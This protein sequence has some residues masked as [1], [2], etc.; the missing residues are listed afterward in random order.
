MPTWCPASS[1]HTERWWDTLR[2]WRSFQWEESP[3]TSLRAPLFHLASW[4]D[5]WQ[6]LL[7]HRLAWSPALGFLLWVGATR[8][9]PWGRLAEALLALTG[10]WHVVGIHSYLRNGGMSFIAW[11][12]WDRACEQIFIE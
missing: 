1:L 6:R 12:K 10:P 7:S 5:R 8:G 2:P 3:N 4:P 11:I 9:E